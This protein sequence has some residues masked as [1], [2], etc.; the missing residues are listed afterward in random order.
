MI[1]GAVVLA[2]SL[3]LAAEA[4]ALPPH[5]TVT[6]PTHMDII[7]GGQVSGKLSLPVGTALDVDGVS[8]EFVLVRI[9]LLKGRVP[10]RDT[11]ISIL[12][13]GGR[14]EAQTTPSP[15]PAPAAK[16]APPTAAAAK[17][18]SAAP[19]PSATARA[20]GPLAPALQRPPLDRRPLRLGTAPLIV[21]LAVILITVVSCW[22]VFA[23]AGKPGWAS[24]VPVYNLVVWLQISGKPVWWIALCFIPFVNMVV[25][26]LCGFALARNFGRGNAFGL[27]LVLLPWIF[28]PVLAFG[29]DVYLGTTG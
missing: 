6:A 28:F 12:D 7:R 21:M 16:P 29:D 3:G 22:R 24:I 18:A 9:R 1:L 19:V 15:A 27:G 14:Y 2:A 13:P 17:P 25:S 10:A 26:V 20:A 23:K 11:D 4:R 8:G 5:I